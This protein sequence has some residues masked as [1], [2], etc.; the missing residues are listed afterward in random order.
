MINRSLQNKRDTC[1][2]VS[3]LNIQA[4][5]VKAYTVALDATS[6]TA[7]GTKDGDQDTSTDEGNDDTVDDVAA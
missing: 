3:L 5:I 1:F 4:S 6:G 2:Q 7:N